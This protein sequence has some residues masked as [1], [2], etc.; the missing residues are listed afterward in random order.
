MATFNDTQT[1]QL[2][3]LLNCSI[4]SNRYQNPRILPCSHTFCYK[5]IENSVT[6]GNFHCPSHDDIEISQKDISKLPINQTAKDMVELVSSINL[7]P[8]KKTNQQCDNCDDNQAVNWCERCVS[9]FC[10]TCTDSIH[11]N[12]RFQSHVIVPLLEKIEA[13]CMDHSSEKFTY[14]C[15]KC[16]A[17]VCR[18]CLLFKHKFHTFSTLEDA[19]AETIGK[20]HETIQELDE[21][22]RNL[23]TCLSTTKNTIHRQRKAIEQEK[24]DIEQIFDNLQY[25]L[26]EQKLA[27][28]KK[29]EEGD[30][31]TANILNRQRISINQ[32]LNLT[33]VQELC[34]KKMIDS[35]D[36][37]Q[38]LKLRSA[39]YR[40]YHDFVE[41]Y[42]KID[43]GYMIGIHTVK[44]FTKDIEQILQIIS[45]FGDINTTTW[46][47]KGSDATIKT[48]LLD[49]SKVGGEIA[50]LSKENT[51]AR[52]YKFILKKLL[53]LRSFQIHS[54]QIGQIT[55]FIV[56]DAG[57][58][59]Q[60]ST[61]ASTNGT[62][63][64]LR[65]PIECDIQNN[66]SL[67]VLTSSDHGSFTYKLGDNQLRMINP[68]CL[69]ESKYVQSTIHINVGSTVIVDNNAAAIDMIL[70]VEG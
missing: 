30:L 36:A 40:N 54:D 26:E 14:W 52:G 42:N 39:L 45:N 66:Y 18:E 68:N 7:S 55:G 67:F 10:Q 58:I 17:L 35:N 47:I 3:K 62:M 43:D 44:K 64:W 61:I 25:K 37:M 28:L 41:Q 5:C 51:I 15:R 11:S 21:I 31:Q 56:N 57:V 65:I 27:I 53:K 2:K 20:F 8:D 46:M 34:V 1:K 12:K 69:V 70:D 49:I 23:T 13:F 19:A 24:Q 38:I 29:L 16:E 9:H 60:K 4:C 50:Y 33:T 59:I 48:T 32:H 63:K 6:N 22:K